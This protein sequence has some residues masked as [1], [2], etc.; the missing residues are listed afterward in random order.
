[1]VLRICHSAQRQFQMILKMTTASMIP[2]KTDR[3]LGHRIMFW[4]QDLR[5]QDHV[6]MDIMS[7]CNLSH[8]CDF[9]EGRER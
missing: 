7:V 2:S 9:V 8:T 3:A 1:M 5:L 6:W 4:G